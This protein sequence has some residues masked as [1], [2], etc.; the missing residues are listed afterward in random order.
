MTN[1]VDKE[2]LE[3]CRRR[4]LKDAMDLM[5]AVIALLEQLDKLEEEK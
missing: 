4:L 3:V 1:K 2:L 5:K